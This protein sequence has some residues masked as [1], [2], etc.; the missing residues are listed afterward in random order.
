M[1]QGPATELY[2]RLQ[3]KYP[4]IDFTVSGGISS[5]ADIERLNDLGLRRV[6]VG[7]AIYENKISL[8]AIAEFIVR[9]A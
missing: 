3:A 6:I 1:L 7:K 5:M 2:T 4:A 9:G 8:Q